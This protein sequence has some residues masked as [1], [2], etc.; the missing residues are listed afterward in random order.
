MTLAIRAPSA[1]PCAERGAA[2][3]TSVGGAERP[4]GVPLTL[5][6]GEQA[7]GTMGGS[8]TAPTWR[9]AG[10]LRGVRT[11]ERRLSP[12]V[13]RE[14]TSI[15]GGARASQE[16]GE[17][18]CLQRADVSLPSQRTTVGCLASAPLVAPRWD[19]SPE[20][21]SFVPPMGAC[22]RAGPR[23]HAPTNLVPGHTPGALAPSHLRTSID[24]V[25]TSYALRCRDGGGL[26]LFSGC[27][28]F[29]A[30]SADIRV[31]A[32]GRRHARSRYAHHRVHVQ[33]RWRLQLGS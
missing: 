29:C 7:H 3:P 12:V 6:G 13:M 2:G 9:C 18:A 26:S 30:A 20:W 8:C 15:A 11:R 22:S 16:R 32:A 17:R 28:R 21:G 24:E 31:H 25:S 1:R 33:R 5:D 19:A 4:R 10:A 23:P 27:C 14:R